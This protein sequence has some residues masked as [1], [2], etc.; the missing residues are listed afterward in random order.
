VSVVFTDGRS[1]QFELF[2]KSAAVWAVLWLVGVVLFPGGVEDL[3]RRYRELR[4]SSWPG[5]CLAIF[6][7]A[8]LQ[9]GTEEVI[10]RGYL[11]TRFAA[12]VRRPWLALCI[13]TAIFTLLHTGETSTPGRVRI[14][15]LGFGLG[16]A[17]IRAN[18]VA[19]LI[20]VHATDNTL[21]A[22]WVPDWITVNR[23]W[24]DVFFFVIQMAIWLKWLF[25]VTRSDCQ[26]NSIAPKV[27]SSSPPI[28]HEQQ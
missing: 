7:V 19:P 27:R 28:V 20:A 18:T 16:I 3:A 24:L 1:F 22:V 15:L 26:Q 11:Q 2:W 23:N 9:S 8:L 13:A 21:N 12:W 17:L 5:V 10:D 14:A 6:V 25:W 4:P